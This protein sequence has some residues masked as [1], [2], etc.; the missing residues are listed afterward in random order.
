MEMLFIV[1]GNGMVKQQER[2]LACTKSIHPAF[3]GIMMGGKSVY[4]LPKISLPKKF[5][6]GCYPVTQDRFD[7]VS[8]C[9]SVKFIPPKS[10][11]WLHPYQHSLKIFV[12][13]LR[14]TNTN[15]GKAKK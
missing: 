12:E 11:S 13:Y 8:L 14:N 4:I 1:A 5:L 3:R 7:M 15:M 9:A 2:H 6:Y 10:N